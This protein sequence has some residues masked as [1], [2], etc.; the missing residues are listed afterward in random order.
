MRV[1]IVGSR[2]SDVV[3][4]DRYPLLA[5]W[6]NAHLLPRNHQ[7]LILHMLR[8]LLLF[9][10]QRRQALLLSIG[11]IFSRF[12]LIPFLFRSL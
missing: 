2:N 12:F 7:I 8:I 9:R 1:L 4:S 3:A 5:H 6:R 10:R 11:F